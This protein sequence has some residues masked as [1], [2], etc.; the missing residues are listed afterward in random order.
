MVQA[1]VLCTLT[2]PEATHPR[3]VHSTGEFRS[4]SPVATRSPTR[5]ELKHE[6]ESKNGREALQAENQ[7]LIQER[8]A[9]EREN[10]QLRVTLP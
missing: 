3:R 10:E 2:S 7:Q 5:L 9:K 8:E 6:Q 1:E 4:P